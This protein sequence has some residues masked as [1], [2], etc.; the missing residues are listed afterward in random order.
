MHGHQEGT[1]AGARALIRATEAWM[2]HIPLQE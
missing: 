1:T 2:R